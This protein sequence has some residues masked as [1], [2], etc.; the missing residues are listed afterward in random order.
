MVW[1]LPLRE[2]EQKLLA[3]LPRL[4]QQENKV[5]HIKY[6]GLLM[7]LNQPIYGSFRGEVKKDCGKGFE[8][9]CSA[10]KREIQ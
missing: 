5:E 7:H 3:E 1:V 10:R 2:W 8:R 6:V 4:P 9:S